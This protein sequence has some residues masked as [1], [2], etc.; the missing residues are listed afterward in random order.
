MNIYEYKGYIGSAEVDV[1]SGFLV[2]KLLFIRDTITYSAETA[3]Q[4]EAAF[5]EAVDDYLATCAQLGDEPDKP[6]T[7]SYTHLTLP[8]K[9][10]V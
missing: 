6:F 3:K 1:E 8:T 7:V 4:L 5:K 10:I 9:R 2:G